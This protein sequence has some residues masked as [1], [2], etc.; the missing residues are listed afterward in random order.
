MRRLKYWKQATQKQLFGECRLVHCEGM[1]TEDLKRSLARKLPCVEYLTETSM[2]FQDP[3]QPLSQAVER[4]GKNL[5]GFLFR[6]TRRK[7]LDPN[8]P[9]VVV[10][11]T[12]WGSLYFLDQIDP[13]KYDVT[14]VSPR[15]YFVFTPL[16]TA[17][18]SG[19]LSL[20]SVIEPIRN[21]MFW[22]GRKVMEYLEGSAEDVDIENKRVQCKDNYGEEFSLSFDKL[23]I[24]IGSETNTFGIPGVREHASF[25]KEV[26]DV[27]EIRLRM[28]RSFEKASIP[29]TPEAERQKLLNFVVVGGGPAGVEAAAEMMDMVHEDINK[30]YPTLVQDAKVTLIEMLPGLIPMFG[31]EISEFARNSFN[32][33][34]VNCLMEHRVTSIDADYVHVVDKN[35][36]D[37]AIPYGSVIWASGVGQVLLAKKLIE[38]IPEQRNNRVLRVNP[39]LEVIGGNKV[40]AI[41]DCAHVTPPKLA[42]VADELYQKASSSK[43]GAGFDWLN[44]NKRSL[45]MQNYC[46]LHPSQCDVGNYRNRNHLNAEEFKTLL[47]D[48]DK[49]YKAPV[50]TAQMARQA[51]SYLA[52][53]FN[54]SGSK[55]RFPFT[56]TNYGALSYV[57]GGRAVVELTYQRNVPKPRMIRIM[58]GLMA[59][60]VWRGYYWVS[61][62]SKYNRI[63]SATDYLKT[64]IKGRDVIEQT[65][66][67]TSLRQK[68]KYRPKP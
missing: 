50:P 9:K 11:G 14:V 5:R 7:N 19:T 30:H 4:V 62:T 17:A 55:W 52:A 40:Y 28:F 64:A 13:T 57:G 56:P 68:L 43:S 48:L 21:R 44:R 46:Q 2:F 31:K 41:G 27:R 1:T 20:R 26:E 60:V 24:A 18:L 23:V 47:E 33:I 65:L 8:R 32:K 35:K 54:R 51:G 42:A 37:I 3:N 34:G 58:G 49:S 53:F 59:N 10:L 63:L 6:F 22:G 16:L 45:I 38:K 36:K 15:S 66:E 61:Q 25:M 29:G 67:S 12:G 39:F